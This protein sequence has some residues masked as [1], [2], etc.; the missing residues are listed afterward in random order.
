MST[1]RK[2]IVSATGGCQRFWKE[3]GLSKL[4]AVEPSYPQVSFDGYTKSIVF[5]LPDRLVLPE[6]IPFAGYRVDRNNRRDACTPFADPVQNAIMG[7]R[8]RGASLFCRLYP[9]LTI[10]LGYQFPEYA[11]LNLG[12]YYSRRIRSSSFDL[13]KV[14]TIAPGAE[15]LKRTSYFSP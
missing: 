5:D 1:S 11:I 10:P 2:S 8:S 12:Q 4:W 13:R 14:G 7:R 6:D 15:C 9:N 3:K